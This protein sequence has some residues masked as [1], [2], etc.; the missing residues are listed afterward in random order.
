M[1]EYEKERQANI[2]ANQDVRVAST[3]CSHLTLIVYTLMN[4]LLRLL[5]TQTLARLGLDKHTL[6][7]HQ[8]TKKQKSTMPIAG[9]PNISSRRMRTVTFTPVEPLPTALEERMSIPQQPT[10]KS[11]AKA[12]DDPDTIDVN[13]EN[14]DVSDM[15]QTRCPSRNIC[16]SKGRWWLMHSTWRSRYRNGISLKVG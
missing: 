14:C 6:Q 15:Y 4:V 1:S 7:H 2:L 11:R 16:L 8:K 10:P 5:L 9:K 3:F 13:F 12:R